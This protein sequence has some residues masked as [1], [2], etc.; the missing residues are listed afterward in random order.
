MRSFIAIP[1]PEDL[2][3]RLADLAE[4]IDMGR[5]V[6][7]E[8]MHVTLAFL[9]DQSDAALERIHD[10]LS[11]IAARPFELV[12]EGISTLGGATPRIVHAALRHSPELADLH[13]RIR[14]RLHG[15]GIML[16]RER[17]VPH[18]TLARLPRHPDAEEL[19]RLARFLSAHGTWPGGAF[20]VH[21]FGLFAS[22]LR[23][24][25]PRYEM[26]AEYSLI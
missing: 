22:H 19:A 1:L 26:L 5:P 6:P 25:G 8:N 15:A 18:V 12:I 24:E 23:P 14:S 3:D 21:G 13:R 4:Q 10:T 2:A 16:P 11:G 9:D 17:F 20:T 7:A